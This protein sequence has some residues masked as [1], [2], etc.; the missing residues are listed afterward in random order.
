MFAGAEKLC[1]AVGLHPVV[2]LVGVAVAHFLVPWRLSCH[3]R[4]LIM[5]RLAPHN[6]IDEDKLIVVEKCRASRVEFNSSG[7]DVLS[8][9]VVFNKIE[10]FNPV[11]ATFKPFYLHLTQ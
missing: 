6:S 7:S 11:S 2:D 4:R 8:S 9:P 5:V 3:C 10:L 1:A